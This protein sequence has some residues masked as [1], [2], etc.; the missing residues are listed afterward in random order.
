MAKSP[1]EE[2]ICAGD[3]MNEVVLFERR[4]MKGKE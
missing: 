1:E 3:Q 4:S 2:I